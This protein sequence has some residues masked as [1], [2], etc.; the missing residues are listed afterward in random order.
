M[1]GVDGPIGRIGKPINNRKY[2]YFQ[3]QVIGLYI[4][5]S[6]LDKLPKKGGQIKVLMGDYGYWPI[7]VK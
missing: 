2:L 4:E 7:A 5:K 6:L 1:K 3:T